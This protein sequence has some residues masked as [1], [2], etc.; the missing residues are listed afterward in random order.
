MTKPLN[1]LKCVGPKLVPF[2]K[3]V[4]IYFVLYGSSESTSILFCIAKCLPVISLVFFVLLHGMSLNEYYRYSRLILTGLFFSVLGDVFLVWKKSYMNFEC[5]LL[6]FAV[7]QVNYARAFGFWPFNPYAGGVFVGLGLL[8][9]SYLSPGLHG[10]MEILAPMYLGL[11]CIMGWRAVARVQFFDDLWTWTKLCGCAGAICFMISDLLIAVDK[12]VVDVPFSHQLIMVSYY[13]AQ[14]LIS[15]SVVDSQ[16][17]DIIR[18]QTK[19]DNPD[20]IDNAKRH[21]KS[22]SHHLNKENVKYQLEHLSTTVD[23]VKENLSHRVDYVKEN[24][25][26]RVDSVKEN[27]SHR[28]DSVKENLSHGVDCVKENLSHRVDYVKENLSQ[29]VDTVKDRIGHLSDQI[30][31]SNVKGQLGQLGGHI[32]N[33]F[34]GQKRD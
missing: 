14:L 15:L 7:A 27:L 32:S 24:L 5:G 26:H 9:Y 30:T 29:G 20:V 16:V 33:H 22:L 10:M 21:V 31:V 4:A 8:V 23:N 17:E 34:A 13:A 12:F 1:V 11:I 28:V 19:H 18:L 6:M 25:S 3:T 2:F